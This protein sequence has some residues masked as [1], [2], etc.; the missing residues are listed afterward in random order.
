MIVIFISCESK[1]D[2]EKLSN[3]L[4]DAKAAACVS[5]LPVQSYYIW[6]GEKTIAAEYELMIKTT[7]EQFDAVKKIVQ[8]A[9]AYDI[10]QIIAVPVEKV[11]EQY[12]EWVEDAVKRG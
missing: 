5:M 6:K 8:D 10:P 9:L 11:S 3:M 2:A 1:E 7:T 4:I 12:N